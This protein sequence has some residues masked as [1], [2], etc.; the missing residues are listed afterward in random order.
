MNKLKWLRILNILVIVVFIGLATC[1]SLFLW[2]P[3]PNLQGNETL[4]EIH[5]VLGYI[6]FVLI[7]LHVILN[8]NWIKAQY[9][10]KKK[11]LPSTDSTK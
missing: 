3:I 8:W 1:I 9:L 7:V 2:A 5:Q 6:F 11:P 10:K 4:V